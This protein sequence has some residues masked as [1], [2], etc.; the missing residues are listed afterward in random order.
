MMDIRHLFCAR[1]LLDSFREAHPSS[2]VGRWI[3]SQGPRSR[4]RI[5]PTA[6]A[7]PLNLTLSQRSPAVP[8]VELPLT[9]F[10]KL[11]LLVQL[12]KLNPHPAKA[13]QC[14]RAVIS[15][16]G[17]VFDLSVSIPAAATDLTGLEFRLAL[18]HEASQ[19]LDSP[20]NPL[21]VE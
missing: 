10:R 1:F 7:Q 8:A 18:S 20:L 15:I 17:L 11:R 14:T 12:F 6:P 5:V 21:K 2:L 19:A 16:S 3:M 9:A 4:L 13:A